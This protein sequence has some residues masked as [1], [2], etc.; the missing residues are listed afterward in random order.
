MR[1]VIVPGIGDS[2][3]AH[4]QTRWQREWGPI[5]S[6]ITPGS[7]EAPDLDDWTGAVD[8]AVRRTGTDD[9]IIVAHGL[10]CLATAAWLSAGSAAI[11]AA[12]LVA[13]PDPRTPRLRSA[14]AGFAELSLAP[15]RVP[16]LV[17]ASDDDPYCRPRAATTLG[18]AWGL[19][20]ARV[21]ALGHIDSS[22]DL[23][24]WQQGRVLLARLLGATSSLAA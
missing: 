24:G 5:A 11:R 23:G 17:V 12:L 14:A 8:D 22:S 21:G 15:V 6:R 18:R 10:G 16:G 19:P 2:D 4:W 7:W 1:F 9:V 13:A 3:S 20:V